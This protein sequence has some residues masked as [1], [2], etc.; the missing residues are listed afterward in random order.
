[1]LRFVRRKMRNNRV[2]TASSF[3]GLLIAVAFAASIP[4]YTEHALTRTMSSAL[5]EGGTTAP[6][7]SL[8]VRYQAG[9]GT[10]TELEELGS[11]NEYMMTTFPGRIGYPL[12]HSVVHYALTQ[13]QLRPSD[14]EQADN[15]RRQLTMTSQTGMEEQVELIDGRMYKTHTGEGP[16]EAI[17]PE[18]AFHRNFLEVGGT[19]SYTVPTVSGS[20]QVEVAVVGVYRP[21]DGQSPYWYQGMAAMQGVLMV[22]PEVMELTIIDKLK[23]N[24]ATA[25][26]YGLYELSDLRR[27]DL[28]R[29]EGQM[30]RLVQELFRMHRELKVDIS[31]LDLIAKFR[32]AD[33]KL[34]ALLVTLAVPMLALCVYFIHMNAKQSLDWQRNDIAILRSRGY[35]MRLVYGL[36]MLEGLLLGAAAWGAGMLL[37]LGMARVMVWTDGFMRF[38]PGKEAVVGWSA[39]SGW[40]GLAAVAVALVAGI[41]PLGAHGKSSIVDFKKAQARSDRPPLWQRWYLDAALLALAGLGW[42]GFRSGRLTA[43]G[44]GEGGVMQAEPLFFLVPAISMFAAGLVCLRLFPVLLRLSHKAFRRRM[45]VPIHLVFVQLSRSQRSYYPLMIL[46]IMTLGL[47]LFHASVAR[48]M[49]LNESERL[50]YNNGADIVLQPVW[51]GETELFDENGQYI[52]EDQ[53]RNTIYTEP[54]GAPF[55]EMPGVLSS[56]KVLRLEGEVSMAGKRTGKS[57]LMGI[58]NVGFAK[59]A[60]WRDSL[61]EDGDGHP[62]T[63]LRWLGEYEQGA[64]I[65]NTYAAKYGLKRGDLLQMKVGDAVFE[66]FVVGMTDYWPSLDPNSPFVVANLDYVYEHIPLTPYALW[67]DMEENAKAM[68][69]VEHLRSHGIETSALTDARNDWK[70]RK[71][72]PER[73]GMHGILTLGFIVSAIVSLVGYLLF[74]LFSLARR[75]VQ[76]GILRATGL[77]RGQL[78]SMLLLEQLLTTGLAIGLGL[79]I[80]RAASRLFVPFLQSGAGL[81]APPFVIVFDPRDT[82]QLLGIVGVMIAAGGALLLGQIV[83]LRVHQAVKLGE[84]R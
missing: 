67:L 11:W 13:S 29:L 19:Y 40:Y 39:L 26:W 27:G 83:R 28:A 34:Q 16:I 47:G 75:T 9:R 63:L 32:S 84:E 57:S 72:L 48:T 62:F 53:P 43:G 24:L 33:A 61:Y 59:S 25:N 37:S 4:V 7:G 77:M 81:Q 52:P 22:H 44:A 14:P 5:S 45:P 35:R 78:T 65:S 69:I 1:M 56:A 30:E 54:P 66:L 58:D 60:W 64:V 36:F 31:F 38:Q 74:W 23:G 18:E 49:D 51:E 21:K 46:L 3:I 2:M 73:E 6:P 41:L 20:E 55:E 76:L 15:R 82:W 42:Y 8:L 71:L 17:V 50:L 79:A 70:L 68:P 80:G 10:H 12:G